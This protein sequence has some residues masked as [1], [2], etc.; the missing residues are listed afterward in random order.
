MQAGAADNGAP[1]QRQRWTD[2]Y[3]A[4]V[5]HFDGNNIEAAVRE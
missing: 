5:I 2:F 1:R 4:F 3:S